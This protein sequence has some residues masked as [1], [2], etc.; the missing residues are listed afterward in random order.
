MKATVDPEQDLTADGKLKISL[1]HA[2]S[3]L[4]IKSQSMERQ[5]LR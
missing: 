4:L 2:M 3:K 5:M 1:S